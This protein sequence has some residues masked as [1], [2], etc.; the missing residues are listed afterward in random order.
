VNRLVTAGT[1]TSEDLP[2]G[3]EFEGQRF[4]AH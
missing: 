2:A 3:F 1:L 4:F